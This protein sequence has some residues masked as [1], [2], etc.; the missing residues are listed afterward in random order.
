MYSQ[1]STLPVLAT[2]YSG[3]CTGVLERTKL[4]HHFSGLVSTCSILVILVLLFVLLLQLGSTG[5]TVLGVPGRSGR[6]VGIVENPR[7]RDTSY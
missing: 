5:R 4:A 7:T 3:Y 6:T 1:T 2:M